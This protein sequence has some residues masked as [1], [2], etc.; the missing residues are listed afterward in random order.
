MVETARLHQALLD[1]EQ[2]AL[3]EAAAGDTLH[4]ILDRHLRAVEAATEHDL[5]TSV[6]LID[7]T[8][9]KLLHG[10]A[11][12]LPKA[13]CDA[14]HGIEIGPGVG[15]CGTA[16]YLGHP[17]YVTDIATDDLWVNF[18]SLAL[19]HGLRACWSTP[20]EAAGGELVGT[21]AIYYSTPRS[22]K[23]E[24]IEAVRLITDVV[25][26]TIVAFRQRHQP[27]RAGR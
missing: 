20:I 15:S 27:P 10:A 6:L 7:S 26:S 22:P 24:E 16:A 4:S 17:V 12:S 18:R 11:P 2:G 14:I 9:R 19:R 5:L 13:Y 21:F 23:L 1:R 8:G 3:S 25:A